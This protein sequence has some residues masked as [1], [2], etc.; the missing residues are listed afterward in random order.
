M[1]FYAYQFLWPEQ[2]AVQ[3]CCVQLS[4]ASEVLNAEEK[5]L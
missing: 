3:H 5:V 2:T 1:S 4:G